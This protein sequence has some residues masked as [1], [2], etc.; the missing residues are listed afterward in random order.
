MVKTVESVVMWVEGP[1]AGLCGSWASGSQG[2]ASVVVSLVVGL[3]ADL[4]E[5][6][7]DRR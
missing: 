1:V 2:E 7:S 3:F 5:A 4:V 6:A